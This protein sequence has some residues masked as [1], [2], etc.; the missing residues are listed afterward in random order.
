VSL[1]SFFPAERERKFAAAAD[2]RLE[3]PTKIQQRKTGRY[4]RNSAALPVLI[5]A[6]KS[7][8]CNSCTQFYICF[9]GVFRSS[10]D[11]FPLPL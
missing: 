2:F 1:P 10:I 6:R 7:C 9:T 11:F 4:L 5:I 3:Q 8:D